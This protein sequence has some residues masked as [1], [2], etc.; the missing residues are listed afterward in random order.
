MQHSWLLLTQLHSLVPFCFTATESDLVNLKVSELWPGPQALQDTAP[1][2]QPAIC[3]D[4]TVC[5]PERE[6]VTGLATQAPAFQLTSPTSQLPHEK[7]AMQSAT[8]EHSL[9]VNPALTPC[10]AMLCL[11]SQ[12]L[13][14]TLQ[15]DVLSSSSTQHLDYSCLHSAAK[16]EPLLFTL[17]PQKRW[18]SNKNSLFHRK[19]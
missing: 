6:K 5:S 15:A 17:L 11:S 8:A 9:A 7:K 13:E 14:P 4:T 3:K 12:P 2:A 18:A 10:L 19:S 16:P 1:G